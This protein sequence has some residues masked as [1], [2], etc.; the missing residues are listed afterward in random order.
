[1]PDEIEKVE[2]AGPGFINFYLAPAFFP[3]SVA[4]ILRKAQDFGKNLT[5]KGK[6]VI[7]EYTDPNVFKPFH[8]G[9]LMANAIGE[10]LSRLIEFEG[11]S[12]VRICYPSDIGLH[13]AKSVWAILKCEPEMPKESEPVIA[14]TAFLGR[15]YADG[16]AAYENNPV[17]KDEIDVIN[18]KLF[19]K[20]DP[21]INDIYE[22]GRRWSM[23]HFERIYKRVG[24]VF[25]QTIF[26][27]EVA[28]AGKKIVQEF[29]ARGIFTRS[30]GAVI[31]QGELHGLHARVFI[32]AKGLPTYEAK[33]LG[34][35]F[36]KFE[37]FPDAAQSIIVTANEQNDYFKVLR[38]VLELIRPDIGE[39]TK[40][41]SHGMLRLPSGKMSSRT[42]KVITAEALL[43]DVEEMALRKLADRELDQR[44]KNK[45]AEV[46]AVAAIKYSI[47]RQAIGSDIIFDFD[48]SISFE[49][50]SGPY[51]LY[52]YVRAKSVLEKAVRDGVKAA[53]PRRNAGVPPEPAL[54]ERLLY[55]FPEVVERAA[56][57][58]APHL[59]AA[60][61]IEV[62]GA[63]NSFYAERQIVNA[64]DPLSPYKVALT[65]IFSLIMKNGLW[66]LGIS[67]PEH[68]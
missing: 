40:H 38:L 44:E 60:Y 54:L 27:S 4:E 55:R 10:S 24:T 33:E 62:S 6:R 64:A 22:K 31:F 50:D 68:M 26:E 1:K 12:V 23:E 63:F 13:I 20:S 18:Q 35:N 41:V 52:S 53:A 9:H 36:K 43:A 21:K 19:E 14:R 49:G 58:Y 59:I 42:G 46:V 39:K 15:A 32:N 28:L 48:K 25:D 61:L 34:L 57:E 30:E 66:L 7:V 45:I 5:L 51:L 8:I 3:E 29:L 2:I 65:K 56:R 47:L 16:T 37:L 11:A 67:V 17:S